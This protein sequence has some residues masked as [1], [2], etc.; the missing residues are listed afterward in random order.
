VKALRASGLVSTQKMRN[1]RRQRTIYSITPKGRQALEKWLASSPRAG[2]LLEFEGLLRVLVAPLGTR[3]DLL[4]AM[5][6]TRVDIQHL[7]DT[8]TEVAFEYLK[9]DAPFQQHVHARGFVFV[10][11]YR[12]AHLVRGWA[13]R[14][15]ADVEQ[16]PDV[17]PEGKAQHGLRL[18]E[19]V[20]REFPPRRP[21]SLDR[22]RRAGPSG[23]ALRRMDDVRWVAATGVDGFNQGFT[24]SHTMVRTLILP[25]SGS[26]EGGVKRRR[27]SPSSWKF[28][29]CRVP[30]QASF[31]ETSTWCVTSLP[32]IE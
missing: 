8:A 19:A 20:L 15:I 3:E 28:R 6:H 5:R 11:I 18:I 24:R 26:G 21:W 27:R 29:V 4:Q 14:V 25:S 10:F 9:G 23:D 12:Y 30:V 17:A 7:L 16:W 13:D 22:P 2:P 31:H 32:L 1:G